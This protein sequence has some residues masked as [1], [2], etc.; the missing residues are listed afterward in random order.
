MSFS[1]Q[2]VAPGT[3]TPVYSGNDYNLGIPGTYTL[4]DFFTSQQTATLS[5]ASPVG[6]YSFQDSYRFSIG[7]AASGDTLVASLGLGNIIAMSNLQFRLYEVPTATTAPLVGGI[8]SGAIS[9]TIWTGATGVDTSATTITKSFNGV[10][11][12]TYILDVAGI[13]SG[14]NGGSYVGTVNLQ[15]VPLPASFLLMISGL[16]GL[17]ALTAKRRAV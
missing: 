5:T 8:P 12:G 17:L 4:Q 10:Q 13:A 1:Y 16:G 6:A 11:S 14:T 7:A 9:E 3:P 15:P 2:A